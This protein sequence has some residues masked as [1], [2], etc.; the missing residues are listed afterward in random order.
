MSTWKRNPN[1]VLSK[2]QGSRFS[3]N[4]TPDYESG[5]ISEPL[6]AFGGRHEHVD[7]KIGLGLYGPYSL[8][9]QSRPSLMS[10]TVGIVGPPAMAADAEQW[11]QACRGVITNDGSQPFRYP[12]F[13]GFNNEHPFQCELIF[14]DTWRET[15]RKGELDEALQHADFYERIR[16]V[17]AL[18]VRALEV[19]AGREPRPQ[20]VL[21]C[22]PQEVIDYCTVQVTKSGAE[23]RIK[24]PKLRR[25]SVLS[26][27]AAAESPSEEAG[28]LSAEDEDRAHQNLRRGLKAEAM[29]FEFP[30]QLVWPR[31]LRMTDAPTRDRTLQDPAT[32]AWNFTTAL[33]HKAG[34]SPWRLAQVEPG[35]CY[36][37]ISFYRE[38]GTPD[39][40]MRTSMA[41]AFTA[42]GDGYVL[43]GNSFEWD[44]SKGRTPHLDRVT[45]LSLMRGVID[46]Y[47]RQN[48][49]SL[50]SRIVVHKSSR[51]WDEELSGLMDACDVIP[52]KDF[53]ALGWRG[54]QFY[55]TGDY[56]PLRGSFIKFSDTDLLLYTVG[57]IPFLRTYPGARVPQPM[58]VLEHHGD[59]PWN[60]VLQEM[61]ALTKMN[62][63]TADFAVNEPITIAFSKRVG[64]IL[65]ELP[66]HGIEPRQEYR[67]YM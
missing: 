10:I 53:V 42:A 9:G 32:R 49:G 31:T 67:F 13:P 57:Y 44:E 8:A 62:W 52:R 20:V 33:Y 40:K 61:L 18:Y 35:A 28:G 43:R 21:C 17:V 39:P 25:R 15:F 50:P 59:S 34:G 5:V 23:K 30:T 64:Q 55:R 24:T 12:H 58:E 38:V 14:G 2:S 1:S 29:R 19:L 66:P 16:K 37:G 56:P 26:K 41:Q 27:K 22:I 63:N 60:V 4:R 48:R 46:L 65:A 51:F 36:M 11:L 45:A 54:I 6:L 3:Y 47:K 7:P